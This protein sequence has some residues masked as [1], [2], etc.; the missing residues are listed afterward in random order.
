FEADAQTEVDLFDPANH[1]APKPMTNMSNLRRRPAPIMKVM[2]EK[3]A[4]RL[5]IDA[6]DEVKFDSFNTSE[7]GGDMD[8]GGMGG[9]GGIG[10]GAM[11][12]MSQYANK[13]RPIIALKDPDGASRF[14]M[15]ATKPTKKVPKMRTSFNISAPS[16]ESFDVEAFKGGLQQLLPSTVAVDSV[17]VRD[18]SGSSFGEFGVRR[19]GESGDEMLTVDVALKYKDLAG[20]EQAAF[21]LGGFQEMDLSAA[22]GA[23]V[24]GVGETG[25]SVEEEMRPEKDMRPMMRMMDGDG[26]PRFEADAQT[27][28]DL[29]DPANHSH[30]A[31]GRPMF[32]MSRLRR[33]PGPIMKVMDEK[34]ASRLEIDAV[35]EVKFDSFN[36]SEMMGGGM[37]PTMPGGAMPNMSS[38]EN[39]PRPIITMKDGDGAPRFEMNAMKPT[40]KVPKM[41][42]SFNISADSMGS[43]DKGSFES[44]LRGLLDGQNGGDGALA[45][46][47][48]ET[49]DLEGGGSRVDV[50]LK[51]KDLAGAE[52]AASNLGGF[53]EMDLSAALGVNCSQEV[54]PGKCAAQMGTSSAP[55]TYSTASGFGSSAL[56]PGAIAM[57]WRSQAW[58][59]GSTAIGWINDAGSAG[60]VALGH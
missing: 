32:N 54:A 29:F 25:A 10:G 2:D 40:K 7:M 48:V 52:Q 23:N 20:A 18:G 28:V 56:G 55:G 22:L 31:D 27:E 42:T 39:K 15:D 47:S 49:V 30:D 34:G 14:E 46:D 33:S 58:G 60:S 36:T 11:P 51:Y 53:E 45:I 21:D 13:P 1:S 24:T 44:G 8:M 38:Y 57:G 17:S 12:N 43:F 16:A 5:E 26:T 3:G 4:S 37:E 41:R 35:D 19:L 59:S 6:V 50:A 9:M